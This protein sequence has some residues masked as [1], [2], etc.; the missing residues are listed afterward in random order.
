M[1]GL[2]YHLVIRNGQEW[3]L[4]AAPELEDWLMQLAHI[5][6]LRAV[7]TR[8][9]SP[10]WRFCFQNAGGNGFRGES[11]V[12]SRS[13]WMSSYAKTD[14]TDL[15]TEIIPFERGDPKE[16][17]VRMMLAIQTLYLAIWPFGGIPVH[18]ALLER[19]GEAIMIAAPGG[20]GKSTCARRVP[21]PWHTLCDDTV[22]LVPAAG[23]YYAHPLPTW[24]DFLMRDLNN[25]RWDVG[26]AVPVTGIWFLEHGE[27]DRAV[28]IGK[29]QAASR[30]YHSAVQVSNVCLRKEHND[31]IYTGWH[32][33]LFHRSCDAVSHLS[34]GVLRATP[35]GSF[36]ECLS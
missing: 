33:G 31:E 3:V 6:M 26:H 13:R 14:G 4:E 29:G 27:Q 24:S 15:I 34:C 16:D 25:G 21:P 19:D 8:G 23:V 32:K 5:L 28:P 11:W 9:E 18:A 22:L 36:W 12:T 2:S 35:G 17:I 20:T 7:K 30:L 1:T 10:S